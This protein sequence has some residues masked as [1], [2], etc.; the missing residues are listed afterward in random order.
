MDSLCNHCTS[1]WLTLWTCHKE[2]LSSS[3]ATSQTYVFFQSKINH[4]PRL[5]TNVSC[6]HL[7]S[8]F[9]YISQHELI[10]TYT[11]QCKRTARSN[12]AMVEYDKRAGGNRRTLC[13]CNPRWKADDMVTFFYLNPIPLSNWSQWWSVVEINILY[14]FFFKENVRNPVWICRDPISLILGTRFSLILG[15][16][17]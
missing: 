6:T 17:W 3:H 16:R 2:V 1:P 13:A 12:P 9:S 14:R 7:N 8:A 5:V 10:K 15:T 4:I 11:E